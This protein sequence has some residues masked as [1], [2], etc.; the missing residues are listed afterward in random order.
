[1]SYPI[2]KNIKS[3]NDISI[4]RFGADVFAISPTACV[5]LADGILKDSGKNVYKRISA[6]RGKFG[7]GTSFPE[8]GTELYRTL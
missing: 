5:W 6:A 3:I 4:K 1:M 2:A 7:I 8:Y